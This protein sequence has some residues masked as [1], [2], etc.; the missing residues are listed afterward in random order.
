MAGIYKVVVTFLGSGCTR[1]ATAPIITSSP[2]ET[3]TAEVDTEWFAENATITVT[4]TPPGVYEYRLDDGPWQE[5]NIFTGVRTLRNFDESGIHTVFARDVKACRERFDTVPII[6]YP[7]YFTPNG[8]GFHDYWNISTLSGYPNAK[9]YIFDRFGK[10]LKQI[11]TTSLGWDG[12][13]NGSPML[14]DDYWFVVKYTESGINKE[15]KAHFSLK[16]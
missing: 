12:T 8:D 16:R 11:S 6:D 10:L 7:K 3:V 14:A 15:F 9:I 5:S 13:F 2:P 1:T 4:V